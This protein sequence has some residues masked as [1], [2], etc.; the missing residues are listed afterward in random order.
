MRM[1]FPDMMASMDLKKE[2]KRLDAVDLTVA[3]PK[4]VTAAVER[5]PEPP[6][7]SGGENARRGGEVCTKRGTLKRPARPFRR[8]CYRPNESRCTR[9]FTMD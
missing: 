4:P 8:R 9:G 7:R 2:S 3:P 1:Y 5:T 6:A